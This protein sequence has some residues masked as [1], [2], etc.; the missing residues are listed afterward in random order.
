MSPASRFGRALSAMVLVLSCALARDAGAQAKSP[1]DEARELARDGWKALDAQNYKEALEKVTKAEALYHAPTHVLLT[2]NALAGLGRL[3]DALA[4]FEKLAAE[5]IPDAAP[6]AFKEAQDTGRKRMKELLARVPSLLVVVESAD[7]P[8]AKISVDGKPV[9]FASGVAVRFDPG[10]HEIVVE[11]DGFTTAKVPI[12][13]PEKG[14]VVRVPVPLAKAHAPAGSGS[15]IASASIAPTASAAP[16][17]TSSAGPDQPTS[18]VPAYVAFGVAG[19][20]ILA[21]AITG[22]IS[23]A[24]TGDLKARCPNKVCAPTDQGSIDTA[25]ALAHTSTVT[26]VL[27]G[28]AAAAGAVLMVVDLNP[29][30]PAQQPHHTS[31]VGTVRP[32]LSF[33]GAGVRGEF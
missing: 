23:L 10:Q 11:A 30:H 33:G 14:G 24:M 16:S 8:D 27:G 12:T 22:G 17:A 29:R 20:G 21:G 15:A 28:V 26:F 18:R 32:Y 3:V 6:A 5:P 9:N 1:T 25:T 2:G 7:A 13:L 19:A 31:V 4:T